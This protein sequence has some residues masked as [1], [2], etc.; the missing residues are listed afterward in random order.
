M[1]AIQACS[2]TLQILTYNL[3]KFFPTQFI[4][5]YQH[6]HITEIKWYSSV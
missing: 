6:M 5:L 4:R 2:T 3:N 1:L